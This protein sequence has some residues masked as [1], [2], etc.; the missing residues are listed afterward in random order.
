MR[1]LLAPGVNP[2]FRRQV[3]DLVVQVAAEW[4]RAE[5]A[6]NAA[7]RDRR[8]LDRLVEIRLAEAD[9]WGGSITDLAYADALREAGLDVL[10]KPTD[11]AAAAIRSITTQ[12]MPVVAAAL[13]DWAA[14]RRDKKKDQAGAAAI[15]AV[16]RAADPDPWRIRL[17]TAL[18]LPG[19]TA[20][21]AVLKD[22]AKAAPFDV[23]GPVGLDLLGRA[24][25]D[26]GDP[27]DAEAV[28][29]RTRQRHPG[30]VWINYDLATTL[31]KLGRR[32]EA[33]RYYTAARSLRPETAH[34]LA[35]ALAYQGESE[36]AI[37]VFRDLARLRPTNGRHLGCLGQLL[38]ARGR[39]QEA[40]AVLDRAVTVLRDAVRRRPRDAYAHFSLGFSL[41]E[42]GKHDESIVKYRE[43]IRI[44]P[45]D[46][47][48]HDNLGLELQ[49]QG[50]L[51]EAIAE[52]RIAIQLQPQYGAA[53]SNLGSALD[54]QKKFDEAIAHYRDA[55]RI[56]PDFARAHDNL[57]WALYRQDKL[58]QASAEFR[59]AI[60]I[61]PDDAN[62][63]NNLGLTLAVQGKWSEAI[64]E[65]RIATRL[66]PDFAKP[67]YNLGVALSEQGQLAEAIAEYPPPPISIPTSPSRTTTSRGAWPPIPTAACAARRG[68]RACP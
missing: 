7:D 13:D 39:S 20:R 51:A 36:E 53:H 27:S 40:A 29:R 68:H 22:L 67:H 35:H 14:V 44:Q 23:A 30:D 48:A 15:S 9:D 64:A 61:K 21:L 33:I 11:E 5:A 58:D 3:E 32:N 52:H 31:E 56:Q 16:A 24:L 41:A 43:A 42:Q 38:K 57:G 2:D 65:Y 34:E 47:I 63:H 45:D 8:L 28:L 60:R 6:A 10:G 17:R 26:A 4:R 66:D 54:E 55:V 37:A 18:D 59:T 50:K 1:D 25:R 46:A 19:Q 12:P 49:Y 62:A